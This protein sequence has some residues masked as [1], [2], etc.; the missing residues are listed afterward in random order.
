MLCVGSRE[1]YQFLLVPR[2]SGFDTNMTLYPE[3][4]GSIRD[5]ESPPSYQLSST[6]NTAEASSSYSNAALLLSNEFG[7][8][9]LAP[10]DI[11]TSTR[12]PAACLHPR[13]LPVIVV[14]GSGSTSSESSTDDSQPGGTTTDATTTN[15]EEEVSCTTLC[16]SYGSLFDTDVLDIVPES[17]EDLRD[18]PRILTVPSMYAIREQLPDSLKGSSW[19]RCFA[20]GRDGD[21]FV[22]FLDCCSYFNQSLVVIRTMQGHILGGFVSRTWKVQAADRHSYYGTGQ[23]FLFCSH[24]DEAY[25]LR[26]TTNENTS[27]TT[28][29]L[30]SDD[31]PLRFYHWSGV[32]DYCQICDTDRQILCMGGEGDFGWIVK[33]NFERGQTGHCR[34]YNNPP[35]C[36]TW[37]FDIA[38]FEVYGLQPT[39]WSTGPLTGS[40]RW[41][42]WHLS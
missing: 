39:H 23:S 26:G 12:Q 19:N 21:S 9:L 17:L 4:I 31:I 6:I 41:S 25:M 30:C 20:I 5:Q 34:T 13:S 22:T 33:E 35:L 37:T 11:Q 42:R 18:C 2:F 15:H 10:L 3:R 38:D 27:N 32:N 24:P 40:A 14:D 7:W 8:A 36:H 16:R 29:Q 28:A 1:K